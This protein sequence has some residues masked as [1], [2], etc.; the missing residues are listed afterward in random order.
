VTLLRNERTPAELAADLASLGVCPGD[1]VMV[2]A[3]LRAIGPVEGRAGGVVD[4]LDAAVGPGGTLLMTLGA[5][6]DF[7]WVNE[8]PE[9][10]REALLADAEPFDVLRT[11]AQAD[12]GYL[13]EAFRTRAGT[14]VTDHPEGRFGARGARAAALL[15]SPPWHDYF[16]PGSPLERLYQNGGRV[17]RLGASIETVTLLHYAEYLVPLPTKRCVRRHRRVKRSDGSI[18]IVHVDCLDDEHGIVA[19]PDGDYFG[20]LLRDYLASG[21]ARTGPVG[22][23]RSEL[24]EAP[25]LV[26]FAVRW[27]REKF[28]PRTI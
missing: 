14:E 13:A 24:V 25:D 17:L 19:Y 5:R 4:A 2:H 20:F 16:G 27:M 22:S 18:A 7:D 15:E 9:A 26:E 23:A 10:E 12:V 8:R 3:S 11:P 6:N 28:C 1:V 21:R